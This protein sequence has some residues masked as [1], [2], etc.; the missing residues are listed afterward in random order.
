MSAREVVRWQNASWVLSRVQKC[1]CYGLA[2]RRVVVLDWAYNVHGRRVCT[3]CGLRL[4]V[5]HRVLPAND[6][7]QWEEE[8]ARLRAA[9]KGWRL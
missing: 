1:A 2:P 6:E 4:R 8:R 5:W 9:G 7:R 3:R